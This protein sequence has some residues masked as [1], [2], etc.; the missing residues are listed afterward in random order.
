VQLTG[1]WTSDELSASGQVF[2]FR[3]WALLTEQSRGQLHIFLPLTDR[4]IDALAHRMSDGRYISIQAKSRSVLDQGEVHVVVWAE[5]LKDDNALLVCGLVTEGGLGP[6][7]LV[8]PEGAFKRLAEAS[9]DG[10]RPI[11]SARFGMHPRQQSRFYD[12]LVPTERLAERFGISPTVAAAQPVAERPMW[13]SDVGFLGEAKVTLLLAEAGDLNLF[14]PFP[15]LETA[16]L[17]ALQMD[18]RRAL[19]IQVKTRSID[20]SHSATTVNIRAL[21]F[22]P[23]PSTYFVILAWLRGEDR[24]HEDCLLIPSVEFRDVCQPEEVNGQLKFEWDPTAQVRGRLL[25]Y[26]TPLSAL[27]L[28]ILSRLRG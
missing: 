17:V 8:I 28:E 6:T 25:R 5:S 3:L 18:S 10:D 26:R 22:R 1:P 16:E 11:Y 13:R 4:G 7:M 9:H 19:G 2:E 21:S 20:A 15:D 23:A 24:F 14:R 12:F 27:R